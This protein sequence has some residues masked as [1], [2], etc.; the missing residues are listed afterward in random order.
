PSPP[1]PTPPTLRPAPRRPPPR[2]VPC[3]ST[4]A[5]SSP[6]PR[7]TP[8]GSARS[9]PASSRCPHGSAAR[10]TRPLRNVPSRPDGTGTAPANVPATPPPTPSPDTRRST[11][12][13]CG[14]ISSAR[15]C[16]N[17]CARR[18]ASRHRSSPSPCTGPRACPRRAALDLIR[19]CHEN[20][21]V[22][23]IVSNTISGR[24][25]REI[26]TRYGVGSLLGPSA[27]S[28][29]IGVRKPGR[30]IFEAALAGLDVD[31][32]DVVYV[33]DK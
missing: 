1:P 11:P 10:S 12:P 29:E 16:P 17:R 13:P 25:V 8:T 2:A 19:W 5:G 6:G 21:I 27:Y 31:R 9:G 33:G 30:A 3:C 15:G 24:G 4:T 14:A 26:L 22:V 20:D 23:G 7:R 18:C 28:D 32:A